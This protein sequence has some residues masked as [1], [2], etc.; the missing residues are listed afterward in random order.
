MTEPDWEK[1]VEVFASATETASAG[2]SKESDLSSIDAWDSISVLNF[3]A[4]VE[5]SFGV[6]MN[7]DQISNCVS[8]GELFDAVKSSK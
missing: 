5:D 3:I 4:L 7:P 8:L 6:I 1:F 2:Y